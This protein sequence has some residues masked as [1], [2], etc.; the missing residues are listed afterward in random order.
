MTAGHRLVVRLDS[1]GD[2]LV[3]G[4]AVRAVANGA[5]RVSVLAGRLGAAAAGL[6][7]GVDG[8]ISW[9][10]P[11]IAADP[12]GVDPGELHAVI[13]AIRAAQ[14]DQALVLTSFHQSALP[15]ALVLRL[16]GVPRIAAMSV[17][18]PGS[19][20]DVRIE[21]P[22]DAP[23]PE[24]MLAVAGAAGYALPAGDDGRLRVLL[25]L[26]RD[27]D[28]PPRYV[29]VHPGVA[30]PARGYPLDQ[31]R[32]VV[33]ALT[34]AGHRVVV[35]GSTSEVALT[36]QVAAAAPGTLDLGGALDLAGLGVALHRAEAVIVANTG[37]AHLA[38]AVGT[39]IVSLF[40]PVVPAVCWAPYGV[41]AVVLGDQSAPCRGTRARVCPVEG[42]PC[43]ASVSPQDVV[44]ALDRLP[45]G[46][47][48]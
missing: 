20:V 38:A 6:L 14:V 32:G 29:V 41:P 33:A 2:V 36:A 31:W 8:V 3:S 47:S 46:V 25:P 19:L 21:P 42:H 5:A 35:T 40:A 17:D 43:L 39:P 26:D 37:P 7:P 34:T 44:A 28:L 15:T 9:D 22:P 4:P 13:E 24:R 45:D 18:Y 23:E 27:L 16:A 1:M 30:A 48:A 10:C 12:A 11:W